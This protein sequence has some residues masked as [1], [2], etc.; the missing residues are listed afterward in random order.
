M[1]GLY[2]GAPEQS[3]MEETPEYQCG[4][5]KAFSQIFVQKLDIHP[6]VEAQLAYDAGVGANDHKPLYNACEAEN[7]KIR[8]EALEACMIWRHYSELDFDG[9]ICEPPSWQLNDCTAYTQAL[10]S[11]VRGC[12]TCKDLIAPTVW[13]LFKLYPR[14]VHS[15]T[16]LLRRAVIHRHHHSFS[17]HHKGCMRLTLV[18]GSL[19]WVSNFKCYLTVLNS[20]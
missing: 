11:A 20:T 18:L 3:V 10:L 16:R 17:L 12:V 8:R 14:A 5:A 13:Y 4:Q 7:Q 6:G 1:A 15:L 9:G 19:A 2:V